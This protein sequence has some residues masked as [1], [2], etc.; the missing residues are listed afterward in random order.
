MKFS[1][2]LS[3]VNLLHPCTTMLIMA[4]TISIFKYQSNIHQCTLQK[5]PGKTVER[6]YKEIIRGDDIVKG[7]GVMLLDVGTANN[8][9]FLDRVQFGGIIEQLFCQIFYRNQNAG[10][11]CSH[12]VCRCLRISQLQ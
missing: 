3:L 2:I 12:F 7:F 11:L 8:I 9:Y 5:R 10:K 1:L 6:L 4:N